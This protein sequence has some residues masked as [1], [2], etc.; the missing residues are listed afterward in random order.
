MIDY[1][2]YCE[3]HRL[4]KEGLSARQIAGQLKLGRRTVRQ[5]LKRK[6]FAQRA[7]GPR[8]SKLDPWKG[9]IVR[10]LNLHPYSAQQIFQQLQ[11]R[12]Y[13]GSYS[14][15][16]RFVRQVRPKPTNAFLTLQFAPG[17]CAQVDWGSAGLMQVGSTRRRVSFFVMVLC[18][19]RR[20]YVEFTLSEKLEHW[21]ACHQSAF[22]YFNGLSREV[23]VDNCK[24]AVLEH[25][26][27]GPPTFNPRYLDFAQHHGFQIKACGPK[28]PHQKGRVENAVAYV[29]RNFLAGLELVSLPALNT[30][31][32]HWLDTVANVR[33]H[34]ETHR[35]P[36]DLFAEEKLLPLHPHPYGAAR[37]E[38]LRAS[39]RFRITVDTNTYSVPARY[40]RQVLQVHI[41]PER[42]L[43]HHQNQ[44]IAEHSRRYDRHQD[45]ES[46]DH[47]QPLLVQRRKAREQQLLLRFLALS[48]RAADYYQELERR[49]LNARHHA[50]QI[51]ALSETYGLEPVQRAMEDAFHFQAFS[52][53]YIANLLQQRLRQL[54]EPGALQLTRP[55]DLLELDLPAPDLSI[56]EPKTKDQP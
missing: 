26:L 47:P 23:M 24:V 22:T 48:P 37:I 40:A 53:Q 43:F 21:L 44:L 49:D 19:S 28:Q 31:V 55:T 13:E 46:P 17:E 5:W 56:Y 36:I 10:L 18:Y 32:R 50:R 6:Q 8:A 30:A 52:S 51:L 3:I 41:Y 25:P 14:I 4:H 29:K 15:L 35:R 12:G 1:S 20:L 54:P 45:Y 34:G 9:E 7:P 39:S 42:I 27:G 2:T 33:V 11:S 16:K 38:D